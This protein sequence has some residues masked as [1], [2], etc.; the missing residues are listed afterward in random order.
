MLKEFKDFIAR[1][2]VLDLAVAV[3]IGAAF[4]AVVLSFVNDVLMPIIA[5]IVG[6]P[7]FNSLKMNVGD[8]AILYG[9]FLTIFVN[10]LF[11]AAAVFLVVKAVNTMQGPKEEEEAAASEVDLLAEIRDELRAQRN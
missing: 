9:S 3:V 7:D 6:Q 2:N 1:G 8:S 11:I 5:A 4:G 10:F